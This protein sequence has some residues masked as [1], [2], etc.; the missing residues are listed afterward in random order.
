MKNIKYII[1]SIGLLFGLFACEQEVVVYEPKPFEDPADP[2]L[3]AATAGTAD[4]S[5]FVAVGNSLTSGYQAGALFT[6]GQNNSLPFIMNEKFKDV[7]A[8]SFNQ[9]D[10]N[11]V[12]G[13]SGTDGT[14]V[15]GRLLLKGTTP[16]PQ[17]GDIPTAFTGD[18]AALNN[19]GVPGILL[20]QALIAGTG[21]P[22]H[23]FE[24]G[25]YTRFASAP[26]T[27]TII[28]DAATAN[29]TF[30]MFYLGN[31]DVLG[32]ASRGADGS[33]P[34][35]SVSDFTF[36]YQAALNV[37]TT[38]PTTKGVVVNIGDI[39]SIP[40]FTL[41][42]WNA[43]PLDEA[44]ADVLNAGFAGVNG[45][46][47]TVVGAGLLAS[48]DAE[49][50]KISYSEGA[51]PVLITDE[52]LSSLLPILDNFLAGGLITATQ[53]AGLV[54]FV[55]ARP[56]TSDDLMTL[57]AA[58]VIGTE[59]APNVVHGVS[60]PLAD[61]YTLTAA[62]VLEITTRITDF[63][64][65][66]AGAASA[67]GVGDR[68]AHADM[69]AAFKSVAFGGYQ[70]NT[71]FTTNTFAPPFGA[72]SEDGVHPNSRGYAWA[73]GQI[74]EA[75]NAKFGSTIHKPDLRLYKGTALPY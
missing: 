34:L 22:G 58:A 51:N 72:F 20:G 62:E 14:N 11:S 2:V 21:T 69:N 49:A 42:P 56:A 74:I 31:N 43:V 50:R 28:G 41:V 12:N 8:G 70:D 48:A 67:I 61:T 64:Q 44:T 32:Y 3:P 24:N 59:L 47:D 10:I 75:I 4:F 27:S 7:G 18:K 73:A 5:K 53:Y 30:F 37:L 15:F 25:L 60:Y 33:I 1:L 66:I 9:P 26:G 17:P 40:F 55:Q 54:P 13:F 46:L 57:R 71:F 45:F 29:G 63:N 36:Q 35:T 6:E 52:S 38:N 19:F 23:P 39:A 16:T 65:A 68:V